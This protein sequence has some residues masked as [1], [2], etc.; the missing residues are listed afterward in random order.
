MNT[1]TGQA[2]KIYDF[3]DGT[4]FINVTVLAPAAADLAPQAVSDLSVANPQGN[5]LQVDFTLPTKTYN[6]AGSLE[7]ELGYVI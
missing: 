1:T 4:E 2:A 3:P 7:G 5:D 6:G